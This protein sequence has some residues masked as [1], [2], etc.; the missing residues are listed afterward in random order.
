MNLMDASGLRLP[1][2]VGRHQRRHHFNMG[3]RVIQSGNIV[4][5]TATGFQ[6]NVF[7]FF[8]Y[9][10]NG[11]QAIG[12]EAGAEH[13]HFSDAFAGEFLQRCAGVRFDPLL[14]AELRLKA[15][16][17]CIFFQAEIFRHQTR[18]FLAKTIIGIS[19]IKITLRHAVV[20]K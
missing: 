12:T 17:K 5:L 14:A 13:R 3:S 11:F 2:H 1:L 4:V 19:A 18:G 6:K 10:F 15:G 20:G 8:A 16:D 9:L 7:I